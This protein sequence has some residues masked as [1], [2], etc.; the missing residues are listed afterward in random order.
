VSPYTADVLSV[1]PKGWGYAV[2]D[3]QLLLTRD[4]GVSWNAAAFTGKLEGFV[5]EKADFTGPWQGWAAGYTVAPGCAQGVEPVQAEAGCR[6]PAVAY[7]DNGGSGWQLGELPEAERGQ[8]VIG[9]SAPDEHTAFV[10]LFNPANLVASFYSWAVE[11]PGNWRLTSTFRGGRPYAS[12][13]QLVTADKGFVGLRPGAGPIEGGLMVTRDSGKN[14][15]NAPIEDIVG[16][17]RISFPDERLGWLLAEA[18]RERSTLLRT[19]DGGESWER[20]SLPAEI[21]GR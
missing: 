6:I 9:I 5:P 7:T 16:V 2:A 8:T 1:S 11:E 17:S 20:V 4:G 15:E 18:N 14:W 10:L 13:L 21:F 3:H 12:D 19:R